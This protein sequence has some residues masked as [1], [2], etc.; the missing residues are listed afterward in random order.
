[1]NPIAAM[2]GCAATMTSREIA[3][4]TGKEHRNIL[5]DARAM[6]IE[7]HG[8][9]GVLSFEQAY[10][11]P[12]NGQAYPELAL[13][14]R[15]TLI[16]VSG[17]S[18]QMRAKIIDR[19]QELEQAGAPIV[20]RTLA[21]ALR[22]A[23]DQAEKIEAQAA[24]I[25]RQRPAVEFVDRYVEAKSAKGLREVSKILGLKEREFI[26][27]LQ[28]DGI[29]FKQGNYWLPKA[30]YHHAGYFE[31]KTGEANGHAYSQMRFTPAGIA[32]IAKRFSDT[33]DSPGAP[34]PQPEKVV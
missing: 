12:Q 19:W 24:V 17:Y 14:K 33:P 23:A 34:T 15:E 8:E 20:P 30:T 25:E 11:D 27:T 22:L 10:R 13:P 21:Q 6:L 16:L 1:M 2:Q 32:W 4:L 18:V 7:L 26:A 9:G 3:E 31:V 29:I 28:A 5:R